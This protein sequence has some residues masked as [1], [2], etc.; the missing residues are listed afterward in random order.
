MFY[1]KRIFFLHCCGRHMLCQRFVEMKRSSVFLYTAQAKGLNIK[2]L[3]KDNEVLRYFPFHII[4]L[5]KPFSHNEYSLSIKFINCKFNLNE[6]H[7]P[8]YSLTYWRFLLYF[9]LF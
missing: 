9:K 3:V 1:N 7:H 4:T 5:F 2:K 6:V 8:Y